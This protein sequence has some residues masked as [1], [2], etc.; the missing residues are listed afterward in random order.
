[1]SSTASETDYPSTKSARFADLEQLEAEI[2]KLSARKLKIKSET[3]EMSESN[4]QLA[5]ENR[6]LQKVVSAVNERDYASMKHETG[7]L[8]RAQNANQRDTNILENQ[9]KKLHRAC[10]Q[11]DMEF[12]AVLTAIG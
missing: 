4:R 3:V 2:A 8:E 5:A 7:L 11:T 6:L 1:M 12:N 10:K 9:L